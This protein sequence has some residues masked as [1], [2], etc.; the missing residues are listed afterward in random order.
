MLAES[1][2]YVVAKLEFPLIGLLWNV[3]V[4]AK[5]FASGKSHVRNLKLAVDQIVPILVAEGEAVD[6]GVGKHR[7]QGEI[8]NLQV[9]LGEVAAGE[10]A[11]LVR[12]IIQAV[13]RLR[14]V[15]DVGGLAIAELVVQ[16]T[17]VPVFKER[18]RDN[19]RRL[20]PKRGN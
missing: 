18:G 9:V 20:G 17:V 5:P 6:Q 19:S 1:L 11:L 12:L 4:G 8:R 14:T 10:I 16:A 15:A 2:G 3:D 7:V 13:V